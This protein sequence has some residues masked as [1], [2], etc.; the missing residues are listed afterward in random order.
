MNST[1]LGRYRIL[2]VI[3]VGGMGTVVRAEDEVL[4]RMVAI[5][6]LKEEL[7]SDEATAERFRREARIAASLSHHGIAQVYDFA[8]EDGQAFIVMELLDGSDLHQ[9]LHTE[10]PMDPDRAADIIARAADALDHAH[11]SGA[12]HRDVKPAN[13]FL[14][15]SDGVKVTDFGIASAAHLAPVTRTG[16]IVGTPYYLAPELMDGAPATPRS[17]IYALG[18]VL[19][20][21]IAGRPPYVADQPVAVAMAHKTEPVPELEE[22]PD[23][24]RAVAARAMAKDPKE[25]FASA[26]EMAG[27]LRASDLAGRTGTLTP[28]GGTTMVLPKA[29]GQKEAGRRRIRPAMA[30][31]ILAALIAAVVSLA[32]AFRGDGSVEVPDMKGMRY[33]AAKEELE[34]LGL[35]VVRKDVLGIDP[36]QTVVAQQPPAGTRLTEG[37]TVELS[38][39]D[40]SGV[41]VP[42]VR[43]LSLDAAEEILREAGFE[44]KVVGTVEGPRD[45]IVMDQAPAAGSPAAPGSVVGLTISAEPDEHRGRGKGK[46]D[47]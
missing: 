39:S 36:S 10:G 30:V 9:I 27:A 4:G 38:V 42:S 31:T 11:A 47:D 12:V 25:R 7:A 19:Y 46:D 1:L 16:D 44:P 20:Q 14:T 23:S 15:S 21:L 29:T 3:G 28:A 2:E 8:E 22:A 24:I 40:G 33:P 5:K 32:G 26:E 45:D 35:R 41:R 37:A 17:D 34:D 6:L 13:I 43:N 18:C